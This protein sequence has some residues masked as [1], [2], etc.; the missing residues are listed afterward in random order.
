MIG[1]SKYFSFNELTDSS[2]HPELVAQNRADAIKFQNAG[3]RLSKLLESVRHILGDKPLKISSG[4]RNDRLNN[5]VGSKA[6]SSSHKI[7]E[8]ADVIPNGMT[9]QEAFTALIMAY[10]G[11][12]LPDLRKV[13]HEGTWLH[14]ETSMKVEDHIGFFVSKDNNKT[15]IKVA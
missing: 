1:F 14:I 2:S 3:K 9:I 13:L 7:F 12:L 5:A 10:R 8:A 6:K 11:G 15:W 4:F